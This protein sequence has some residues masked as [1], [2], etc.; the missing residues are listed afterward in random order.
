[1]HTTLI[2]SEK[3]WGI[4]E[5]L[6]DYGGVILFKGNKEDF[7]GANEKFGCCLGGRGDALGHFSC[8]EVGQYKRDD[9]QGRYVFVVR[10]GERG[11]GMIKL[12]LF[13][14]LHFGHLIAQCLT[15]PQNTRCILLC[16][17]I[18]N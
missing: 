14:L 18:Q 13:F 6:K 15:T 2:F 4:E 9:L 1:M 10:E 11:E 3:F 8:K 7:R 5:D 16:M 17:I 12:G